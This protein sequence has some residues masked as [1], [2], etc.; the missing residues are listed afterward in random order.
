MKEPNFLKEKA[1]YK[2]GQEIYSMSLEQLGVPLSEEMLRE[3]QNDISISK[4]PRSKLKDLPM[5]K[6]GTI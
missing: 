6:Y 4:G 2:P 5:S 3:F 1:D